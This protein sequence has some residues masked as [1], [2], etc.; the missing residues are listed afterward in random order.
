MI[1]QWV[2]LRLGRRAVCSI[3]NILIESI[4]TSLTFWVIAGEHVI[5]LRFGW[6][7]HGARAAELCTGTRSTLQ[8]PRC[9]VKLD[10]WES[11]DTLITHPGLSPLLSPGSRSVARTMPAQSPA[12]GTGH[13]TEARC[14]SGP[15]LPP[16]HNIYLLIT[17]SGFNKQTKIS[18]LWTSD[19]ISWCNVLISCV[20]DAC[21]SRSTPRPRPP[22]PTMRPNITFQTY[23][24][25]P[26]YAAWYCLNGATCFTVKIDRSI[27]YNCEWVAF[28][29]HSVSFAFCEARLDTTIKCRVNDTVSTIPTFR[30]TL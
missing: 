19:P 3:V 23:A 16:S 21:S 10:W 15:G 24:C 17:A 20:A 12:G 28:T 2:R 9:G 27:L 14:L 26:A 18:V 22:S 8:S 11:T 13:T 5:F 7:G 29:N 30:N 1:L 6:L 25:P 4:V